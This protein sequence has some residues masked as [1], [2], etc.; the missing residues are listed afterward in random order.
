[1]TSQPSSSSFL[2]NEEEC[3]LKTALALMVVKRRLLGT[4]TV[5]DSNHGKKEEDPNQTLPV[6]QQQQQQQQQQKDQSLLLSSLLTKEPTEKNATGKMKIESILDRL[7][8]MGQT[9]NSNADTTERLSL[10]V[11]NDKNSGHDQQN[12]PSQHHPTMYLL[13]QVSAINFHH[14]QTMMSMAIQLVVV[15]VIDRTNSNNNNPDQ[16]H[17]TPSSSNRSVHGIVCHLAQQLDLLLVLEQ[18]QQQQKQQHNQDESTRVT[19]MTT[20]TE[21]TTTPHHQMLPS[22]SL[23]ASSLTVEQWLYE[24]FVSAGCNH[25]HHQNHYHVDCTTKSET[26]VWLEA[27][28]HIYQLLLDF[29][30]R[31]ATTTATKTTS[32]I[33]CVPQSIVRVMTRVIQELY[34]GIGLELPQQLQQPSSSSLISKSILA[35]QLVVRALTVLEHAISLAPSVTTN[36]TGTF[37]WIIPLLQ[38]TLEPSILVPIGNDHLA[39][40]VY[41]NISIVGRTKKTMQ[42]QSSQQP[43]QRNPPSSIPR[44]MDHHQQQRMMLVLDPGAKLLIHLAMYRLLQRVGSSASSAAAAAAA[45]SSSSSSSSFGNDF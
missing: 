43:K 21:T 7:F 25:H 17:L 39:T 41:D 3:C 5:D 4:W 36:S 2:T 44:T 14:V 10:P 18:Q 12:Y 15:S 9:S 24:T 34:H 28:S 29:T 20:A 38:Q 19:A 40:F 31:G 32:T 11:A 42:E 37:P 27:T 22:S 23:S 30:K 1:M 33:P 8:W 26:S 13:P 6:D 35:N 45:L 16:Q